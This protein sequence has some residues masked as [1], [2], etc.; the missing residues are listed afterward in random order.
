MIVIHTYQYSIKKV[1]KMIGARLGAAVYEASQLPPDGDYIIVSTALDGDLKSVVGHAVNARRCVAYLVSEGVPKV[2]KKR[3]RVINEYCRVVVPSRYVKSLLEEA[4]FYVSDVIPHAVEYKE[5]GLPVVYKFGFI[6]INLFRKGLD[7]AVK[8]ASLVRAPALI[9]T[10]SY[11]SFDFKKWSLPPYLHVVHP[12][13]GHEYYV[14]AQ[15]WKLLLP[16]RAE[17]FSLAPREYVASTGRCAVVTDLPVYGDEPGL[18]KCRVK[19]VYKVDDGNQVIEMREPDP[20]HCA[21]LVEEECAGDAE[22]MRRLYSPAL[23][24]KFEEFFK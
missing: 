10:T 16:S 8:V 5:V 6:G 4:G 2:C 24:E 9:A 14:Y 1:A 19:D 7:V 17:G 11:G 21:K 12:P 13:A 22:A 3:L 18:L 20:E 23:Y 15:V